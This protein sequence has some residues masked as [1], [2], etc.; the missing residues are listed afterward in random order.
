MINDPSFCLH[1]LLIKFKLFI[2][3]VLK[4]A[5]FG[6]THSPVSGPRH[7]SHPYIH[8]RAEG[9]EGLM[10]PEVTMMLRG[11][12]IPAGRSCAHFHLRRGSLSWLHESAST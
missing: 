5:P 2:L 3:K 1:S 7:H 12:Y 11:S 10:V 4:C 9:P 8:T 6:R